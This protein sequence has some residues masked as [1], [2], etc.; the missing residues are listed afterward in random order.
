MDNPIYQGAQSP[1][2]GRGD[3]SNLQSPWTPPGVGSF[4]GID[5]NIPGAADGLDPYLVWSDVGGFANLRKPG[6]KAGDTSHIPT[7]LPILVELAPGVRLDALLTPERVNFLDVEPAYLR[8]AADDTLRILPARATRAF[9]ADLN[10]GRLLALVDRI[11]LDLPQDAPPPDRQIEAPDSRLNAKPSAKKSTQAQAEPLLTGKVIAFIDD[12]CAFA[13]ASFLQTSATGVTT[14]IKRLWDQNERAL[15]SPHL[16]PTG[17]SEGRSFTDT[18]LKAMMVARTYSGVIDEDAVYAD[19]AAGTRD[20]VNRL[21]RR[22][23]HGTH[24]MDLACGPYFLEDTMCTRYNA[25]AENP[26]W[27][28]TP[29]DANTAPIIFVQLPMR[30]VQST[31]GKGT[32]TADV[33][34]ALEYISNQCDDDAEIVVNLSW[35]T[36]AGPHDG[37]TL[38]E[39]GID[40]QIAASR[41]GR[42]RVVIPA[43]N[44]AQS[45]THARFALKAGETKLLSWRVPADDATESYLEIW[46]QTNDQISITITLPNGD[47]LPAITQG[48]VYKLIDPSQPFADPV[49]ILGVHY[50]NSPP[51]GQSG[52]C[53]LLAIAPTTSLLASRPVAPHGLWKLEVTNVKNQPITALDA[54]IE[55]DDVAVGTRR[56]ARQSTFEDSEYRKHDTEDL[57]LPPAGAYVFREGIFNGIANGIAGTP[58][59]NRVV[60]VGGLRESDRSV[61][62]YS[63]TGVYKLPARPNTKKAIDYFAVSE[64]S[65]TLHGVRAA[66]TRSGGT[67]RFSG[68]SDAAPQIARDLLNGP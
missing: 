2:E 67:V 30:T 22:S 48:L 45:R 8:R 32:L 26:T 12:G 21:L 44:G 9:F 3:G 10:S 27:E 42:L 60:R 17:F 36:L 19:F 58:Q 59:P 29:D 38:L 31:S 25:P 33:L 53:A 4:T 41:A 39:R 46:M 49:S 28:R 5:Y 13:H 37:S 24:V 54:Y 63:P 6:Q 66:G 68:T 40:N 23:A 47:V 65:R 35:G 20:K 56:G 51:F 16:P 11:E 57:S 62:E 7:W 15:N 18:D 14:R 43:G 1:G 61:A 50:A 52:K 55:R 34:H 64:E